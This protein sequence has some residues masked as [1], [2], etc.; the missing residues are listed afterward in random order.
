MKRRGSQLA[1]MLLA[2]IIGMIIFLVLNVLATIYFP[3]EAHAASEPDPK[4]WK[5]SQERI[6]KLKKKY[7]LVRENQGEI[8]FNDLEQ[9]CRG[10][11]NFQACVE[12]E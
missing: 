12:W 4:M 8:V 10:K 7:R 11:G 3:V 5:E 9:G 6:E 2:V 1:T